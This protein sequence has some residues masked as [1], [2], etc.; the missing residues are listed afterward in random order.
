MRTPNLNIW[1]LIRAAALS[2]FLIGL[3]ACGG[4]G[5]EDLPAVPPPPVF[6]YTKPADL[7]DG[8]TTA[9]AADLGVD[10]ARLEAMM[11]A[12]PNEFDI[13]DS[14]AIAYQGQLIFDET[15][16]ASLN[17]F[18]SWVN[19]TNL[20]MHVMF[21]AS[22]SLASLAVGIAIDQ[23]IFAGVDIPY[24]SLFDYAAYDNWDDRKDEILL[25]DVLTMRLGLDWDEWNPP[26][27][28]PDNAMLLFYANETD[29][30]KS[31]LDRP[32]V[33]QPGTTFA[34]NT[35]ASVSL[36]QAI[37]NR[38]P[39]T[40]IDFGF[41][42]A[43]APLNISNV[44][45][46]R[47]PT[48]LPDLGRG[49]FLTTRDFLKF[50]QLYANGGTWNGQRIVSEAWV[51]ASTVPHTAFSWSQPERYDWQVSGYGY[52]WW[53]GFFDIGGQQIEAYAARG[54]GEQNLL[55]MPELGLVVA[56]F[57]HA[58]DSNPDEVNQTYQMIAEHI[59][60]ALPAS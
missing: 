57:S 7:G 14:I 40:L 55:V 25:E 4:S 19:N 44:E 15:V 11:H 6:S 42:N 8:W 53:T 2:I 39:L 46:F 23:G 34:Y 47:T 60:P 29:F 1:P 13:V 59:I 16:R 36:G 9:D 43:L 32:L 52:Q 12:L 33:D 3:T 41:A 48:G 30:S 24:L 38:S 28:S 37:E 27:S 21:S 56:V 58:F 18:D 50:G 31:L 49:L 17:E 54:H 45:V 22:K 10:V 20:S 26:Y 35:P 5:G 51:D